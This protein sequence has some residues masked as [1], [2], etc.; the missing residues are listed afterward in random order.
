[1]SFIGSLVMLKN[2]NGETFGETNLRRK[3]LSSNKRG[4]TRKT[5][6]NRCF[7]G[8]SRTEKE[9]FEFYFR[10]SIVING[11]KQNGTEWCYS[12]VSGF[13]NANDDKPEGITI[14]S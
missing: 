10:L 5:H 13:P 4:K 3:P 9:R 2:L 7:H 11:G 1:M 12:M 6:E 14:N 8:L